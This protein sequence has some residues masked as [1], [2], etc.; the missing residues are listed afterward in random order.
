[1][2]VWLLSGWSVSYQSTHMAN[3]AFN[4]SGVGKMSS[5]PVI[6]SY[7]GGDL[8]GDWSYLWPL[9][10]EHGWTYCFTIVNHIIEPY[11]KNYASTMVF[12]GRDESALQVCTRCCVIH[13]A[14]FTFF[15]FMWTKTITQQS[16][17]QWQNNACEPLNEFQRCFCFWLIF[18]IEDEVDSKQS[19]QSCHQCTTFDLLSHVNHTL[20]HRYQPLLDR[21]QRLTW[22]TDSTY[23]DIHTSAVMTIF[24][25][26]ITCHWFGRRKRLSQFIVCKN[27]LMTVGW[28]FIEIGRFVAIKQLV[29][30]APKL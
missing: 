15:I 13:I 30:H 18:K 19:S 24:Q 6:I 7:E 16:C 11:P 9:H 29:I 21:L 1:M 26:N 22:K 12:V 28:I 20:F 17:S 3:S 14:A 27:I 4:L 23:T 8:T 10:G 5:N 2:A 25:V